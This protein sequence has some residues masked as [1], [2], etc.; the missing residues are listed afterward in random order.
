MKSGKIFPVMAIFYPE[1][2]TDTIDAD[3][4][5]GY[6]AERKVL[7]ALE[8][9][10]DK[11]HI[12]HSL[13]WRY[14]D[15]RDGEKI[16]ET[17]LVIFHPDLGILV[18][19][20]KAGGVRV[21]GGR[22]Y[23]DNAFDGS[24]DKMKMSPFE[25]ARRN[26]FALEKI[27]KKTSLGTDILDSTALTHT[28]WFPDITWKAPLPP[29]A[30]NLG[31]ILDEKHLGNP[32]KQL[33]SILHQAEPAGSKWSP[34]SVDT[35]VQTLAPAVNLMPSLGARLGTIRDRLFKMTRGQITALRALRKQTKLLVE[36]CAGSGKTLL[37][38]QLAHDHLREGRQVLFTCYNKNLAEY[39]HSEFQGNPSICVMNFHD[40]TNKLCDKGGIPYNVPEDMEAKRLFFESGAADL[41]MQVPDS[42]L[43]KYDTIIVDEALDFKDAWWIAL[44]S[45]GR[46]DFSYYIFYDRCQNLYN[47]LNQWSPPFKTEPIVLD[48]NVR[49][50]K[51]IGEYAAKLG[52]LTISSEYVVTNGPTPVIKTYEQS[53]DIP[54]ILKNVIDDLTK[55]QSISPNNIVVLSPYK[56]DNERFGIKDFIESHK[57]LISRDAV[58]GVQGKVRL[59]TIQSFKGL[60]A[61]VVILCGIDGHQPACKPA[62]LYV[63]ATRAR[64]LLYVIQK[65]KMESS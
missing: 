21:E 41:L 60:E 29:E 4:S 24:L 16:G 54:G 33:R 27:L 50:T 39:V 40:L 22:W 56:Y 58:S 46:Q 2:D 1:A 62:N 32:E 49:N 23:Y 37:A 9:L 7:E 44:E 47:D 28:A 17:D 61:D 38:V 59:S 55:R 53:T 6:R 15:N 18:V 52:G 14:I 48:Q 30:P 10:D 63:G 36:G 42:V 8:I 13:E 64:S 26:R 43:P 5:G 20:V 34:N 65:A 11:W 57:N 25:Q 31:F 12:F 51:Q 3:E 45:L 35:L 19:E